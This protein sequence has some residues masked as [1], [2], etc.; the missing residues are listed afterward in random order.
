M[1]YYYYYSPASCCYLIL[2]IIN[3]WQARSV[4]CYVVLLVSTCFFSLSCSIS[5]HGFFARAKYYFGDYAGI[6]A[7]DGMAWA[8]Q[9]SH[10]SAG[11]LTIQI[12]KHSYI[13]FYVYWFRCDEFA[14]FWE[15]SP[16]WLFL[17]PIHLHLSLLWGRERNGVF[18]VACRN[19]HCPLTLV[20]FVAPI[21]QLEI[22]TNSC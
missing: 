3:H 21:H 1:R 8:L 2:I 16:V 19:F 14:V 6:C 9:S 15:F 4:L 13:H 5:W 20:S 7:T 17:T 18:N 10:C 12:N 22:C 11:T